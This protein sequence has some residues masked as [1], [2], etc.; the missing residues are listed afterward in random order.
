MDLTKTNLRH[1][2][3]FFKQVY[4]LLFFL[5]FLG[6][7][8]CHNNKNDNSYDHDANHDDDNSEREGGEC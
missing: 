7:P 6:E 4:W 2:D 1:F 5:F 8:P 3:K